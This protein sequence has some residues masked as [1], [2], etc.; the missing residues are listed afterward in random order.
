MGV[1]VGL[2]GLCD[3]QFSIS[4]AAKMLREIVK[5]LG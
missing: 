5:A 3:P 4:S 2:W 1:G